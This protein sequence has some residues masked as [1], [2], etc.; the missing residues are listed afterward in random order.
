MSE[1]I[2]SGSFIRYAVF[3]IG[4]LLVAKYW[5]LKG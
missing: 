1:P 3:W 5:L 2:F 4:M